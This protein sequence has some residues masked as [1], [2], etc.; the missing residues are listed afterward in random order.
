MQRWAFTIP[1]IHCD[2]LFLFTCSCLLFGN[3]HS[4]STNLM[5]TLHYP[6]SLEFRAVVDELWYSV[7]WLLLFYDRWLVRSDVV[8]SLTST[9]MIPFCSIRYIS[10]YFWWEYST[11]EVV[12]MFM[13]IPTVCWAINSLLLVYFWLHP[14]ICWCIHCDGDPT[15]LLHCICSAFFVV[16]GVLL[17]LLCMVSIAMEVTC[18]YDAFVGG[19]RAFVHS[20]WCILLLFCCSIVVDGSDHLLMCSA[21]DFWK[22]HFSF[23]LFGIHLLYRHC[24]GT[25]RLV[26]LL[27]CSVW[28][29]KFWKPV[30]CLPFLLWYIPTDRCRLRSATSIWCYSLGIIT[31]ITLFLPFFYLF[32]QS[33]LEYDWYSGTICST[34]IFHFLYLQCSDA[35]TF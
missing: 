33:I 18:W 15:F 20:F 30:F 31:F 7:R 35:V 23:L 17:I 11:V 1:F 32:I 12:L 27:I 34:L 2:V 10:E 3:L 4:F 9:V 29:W 6:F 21:C 25:F 28:H 5:M 26:T 13:L 19:I 14:S 16:L 22:L 8:H 24:L